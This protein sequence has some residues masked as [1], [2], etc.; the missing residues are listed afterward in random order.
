LP[1]FAALYPTYGFTPSSRGALVV[2]AWAGHLLANAEAFG[3]PAGELEAR[4][5]FVRSIGA[6]I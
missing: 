5:G 3:H 2:E 6:I 4:G 1:G